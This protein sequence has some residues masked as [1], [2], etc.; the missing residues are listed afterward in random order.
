MRDL[1]LLPAPSYIQNLDHN[2]L[3]YLD[4]Q[5]RRLEENWRVLDSAA[6][7]GLDV[8]AGNIIAGTFGSNV[9]YGTYIFKKLTV[10]DTAVDNFTVQGSGA[11]IRLGSRNSAD[12]TAIYREAGVFKLWDSINAVDRFWFE[13]S[14]RSMHG[15]NISGATY[16]GPWI[17]D[18][19]YACFGSLSRAQSNGAHYGMILSL[20]DANSFISPSAPGGTI[21]IRDGY[22]GGDRIR[23]YT[24]NIEF[25][26]QQG[27]VK[28]K[29]WP[30]GEYHCNS[31][32]IAD[33]NG[34]N[35]GIVIA[36]GWYRNVGNGWHTESLA[37]EMGAATFGV[38]DVTTN[39]NQ[40]TIVAR[41]IS[42][43]GW[44][45]A[46]LSSFGE[47][48]SMVPYVSLH[49]SGCCTTNWRKD[50]GASHVV[51]INSGGGCDWVYAANHPICSERARKHNISVAEE[52]GLKT[53]RG[54]KPH[55]FQYTPTDE[56]EIWSWEKWKHDRAIGIW[57]VPPSEHMGWDDWHVGYFAEE[58]ANLVPEVVGFHPDGKPKGIDYGNLVVVAIAAIN[59]LADRVEDLEARLYAA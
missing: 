48:S 23:I 46:G 58:M 26:L 44:A 56:N 42:Q 4:V 40:T 28:H 19:G 14:G 41:R 36:N 8:P 21:H 32:G 13:N 2:L 30:D 55:K 27:A 22:N 15:V 50:S 25:A 17:G 59:E 11:T 10:D 47:S 5:F 37:G 18:A 7:S 9:G 53:I 54:L 57:T 24:D 1:G 29:M 20:V 45:D 33:S 34:Y 16:V 43:G 49:A 3:N 12:F 52:Y 38:N 35:N 39:N 51:N 31:I 6:P